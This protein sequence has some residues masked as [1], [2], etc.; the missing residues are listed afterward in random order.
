MD[1]PNP[2][3]WRAHT[4]SCPRAPRA[5]LRIHVFVRDIRGLS[6]GRTRSAPRGLLIPTRGPTS[7]GYFQGQTSGLRLGN[8]PASRPLS[9]PYG[10]IPPIYIIYPILHYFIYPI[11]HYSRDEHAPTKTIYLRR[12]LSMRRH[13]TKSQGNRAH[14]LLISA[15]PIGFRV[16]NCRMSRKCPSLGT[17]IFHEVTNAAPNLSCLQYKASGVSGGPSAEVPILRL[18]TVPCLKRSC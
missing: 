7:G 4:V 8:H 2:K 16:L 14:L 9:L 1:S 12:R 18:S 13:S 11:L 10:V 6:A 17:L 3:S 5:T 15:E